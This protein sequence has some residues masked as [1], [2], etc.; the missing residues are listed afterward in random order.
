MLRLLREQIDM[1]TTTIFK[2]MGDKI[3]TISHNWIQLPEPNEFEILARGFCSKGKV[4]GTLLTID[5]TQI[6]I[7]AP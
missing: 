4:W 6:P 5:G 1:P 2:K 3:F 7:T